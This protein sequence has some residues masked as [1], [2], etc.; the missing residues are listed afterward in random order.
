MDGPGVNFA[1]R[2]RPYF[3]FIAETTCLKP[4]PP[5]RL[6][7]DHIPRK[8]VSFL[9]PASNYFKFLGASADTVELHINIAVKGITAIPFVSNILL[10]IL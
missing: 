3:L 6:L 2:L 7:D 4:L 10:D 5:L 1:F 8:T 9:A